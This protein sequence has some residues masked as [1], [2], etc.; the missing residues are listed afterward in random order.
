MKLSERIRAIVG[1]PILVLTVLLM[2]LFG[3]AMVYSAGQL[4]IPNPTVAGFWKRQLVWMAIALV[5][6]LMV[7]RIQVRW[8]EWAAAPLYVLGVAMLAATLVIGTGH[9]TAAGTKSW[10]PLG[11]LAFQ[12]SQFAELATILMLGKVMGAWREAPRTIWRLW[13]PI[14]I[15]G[16]PML[17]VLAQ[18]DLGTAM[19]FGALLI[20]TMYWGGTPL[21]VLFMLVSPLIALL[22][23]F[24]VWMFSVYMLILIL[25]VLLYRAQMSEA[26]TVIGANLLAGTIAVP[27]WNHLAEYQ[28]NRL[29]V[30]LNPQLDP[31]GAGYQLIQSQVAIGSGGWFGKGFLHG[32][33]KRLAF[34]PE[35][36]TDFI[37]SVIGEELGFIG[38]LIVILGFAVILWRLVKIAERAPDPF[39]GIIA[40]GIFGAWSAHV[41]VNIGMTIGLMPITGI[42]LPFLSYGGSFL[43]ATYLA[44]GLAERVSAEQGRAV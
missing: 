30:F 4:D 35:Q 19:V 9:G 8:F 34:L 31:K 32:T 21:G 17:M 7:A 44:M 40:F 36:H 41:L 3:V 42:P 20:A 29:L 13:A 1:D 5:A 37:F 2:S 43:L 15:V 33:Q 10:L 23:S 11:P 28:K 18:P 14:A 25:F 6:F 26:V 12:P 27:L 16:V 24:S 38:T 22:L 39:G